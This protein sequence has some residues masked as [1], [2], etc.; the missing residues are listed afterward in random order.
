VLGPAVVTVS[1]RRV[2]SWLAVGLLVLSVIQFPQQAG[3]IVGTAAGGLVVVG[4]SLVSFV[5]SML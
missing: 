2:I 1:L 5:D 3:R 4:R